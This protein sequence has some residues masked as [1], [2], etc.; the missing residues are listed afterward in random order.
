MLHLGP[1]TDASYWALLADYPLCVL[2]PGRNNGVV[3]GIGVAAS[4]LADAF[5]ELGWAYAPAT[6]ARTAS[7][8]SPWCAAATR[9]CARSRFGDR[10]GE[11]R[12]GAECVSPHRETHWPWPA[13]IA[14]LPDGEG[15]PQRR[16]TPRRGHASAR[17][18]SSM[19]TRSPSGRSQQAALYSPP[20]RRKAIAW[21][22]RNAS[23]PSPREAD[24]DRPSRVR[25]PHDEHRELRQHT[26]QPDTDAAEVDLSVLARRMQLGDRHGHPAG[27]ERREGGD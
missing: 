3:F 19:L 12:S 10:P 4:A 27:R 18:A 6:E 20:R 1:R 13:E 26:V 11:H 7:S 16:C 2:R 14:A 9:W 24:V 22:S 15:A 23:W 21:P 25:E 17:S 8:T 5:G